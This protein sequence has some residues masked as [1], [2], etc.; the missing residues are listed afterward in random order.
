MKN[1]LNVIVDILTLMALCVAAVGHVLPW[2]DER[3]VD[4]ANLGDYQLWH[5]TRSAYAL[6]ALAALICLSLIFRWGP[7][8]RRL[9]NLAMFACAFAALLFELLVFSSTTLLDR[10]FPK[11]GDVP[12]RPAIE[13]RISERDVDVGYMMSVVPTGIAV[14][15]CL[16]RMLWTMPPSRTP[17]PV[18]PVAAD[19][20]PV[21][22]M[23][24]PEPGF[25]ERKIQM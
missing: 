9:L 3:R 18:M 13:R 17:R 5:S 24:V 2:F 22:A 23:P 25:A 16:L 1:V 21:V 7:G 6:G 14:F 11:L 4:V 20:K 8:M 12:V 10:A 19:T 15:L